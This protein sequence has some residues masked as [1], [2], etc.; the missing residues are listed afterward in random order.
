MLGY[1]AKEE[2]LASSS[3]LNI[4]LDLGPG[5]LCATRSQVKRRIC[6]VEVEWKRRNGTILRAKLSGLGV[7]AKGGSLT[8]YEVIVVDVTEQRDLENQ[9][10]REAS[11]DPLTGLANRRSLFEFLQAEISRSKRTKRKFSFIM[12]DVDRLKEINDRFGHPVGDEALCRLARILADCSRS[13]DVCARQGGDEFALVLPET[14][15]VSAALVAN[16]IC[17]RLEQDADEP[18]LSV[19]FGIA[20]FPTHAESIPTLIQ[21][22]DTALYAMKGKRQKRALVARQT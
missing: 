20:G 13:V 4:P 18:P 16:R 12:L 22:A 10:R 1:F 21:A 17:A 14:S 6:P 11:T 3:A 5:M 19:S 15:L 7:Y 2:F 8:R 9:L